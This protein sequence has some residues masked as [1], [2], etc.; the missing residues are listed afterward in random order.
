MNDGALRSIA[1]FIALTLTACSS[2]T[3]GSDFKTPLPPPS[4]G[5]AGAHHLYV[6]A[7]A[8]QSDA[9]VSV[10]DEMATGQAQPVRSFT[11]V[12]PID[13]MIPALG[14]AFDS[15]GNVWMKSPTAMLEFASNAS[16]SVLPIG[17][18]GGPA[19]PIQNVGTAAFDAQGN[20]YVPDYQAPGPVNPALS[21]VDVFGPG[22]SGNTPPVRSIAG[23]ATQLDFPQAVAFDSKGN[24]YVA[25]AG[26]NTGGVSVTVYAPGAS[27]NVA[28]IHRIAG[29]N[30]QFG[31]EQIIDV[32]VDGS[33]TLYVASGG[34]EM[35]QYGSNGNVAPSSS[36]PRG[37]PSTIT[38]QIAVAV[39]SDGTIYVGNVNGQ[40][41]AFAP[42]AGSAP[43]RSFTAA[44]SNG[45]ILGLRIGP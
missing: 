30:T 14:A 26:P 36:I 29:P 33:D 7:Q 22:A 44:P 31:A 12:V 2:G 18:I 25:N 11:S 16:G 13:S 5:S 43:V 28:P 35:F 39:G 15:S 23:S 8:G 41:L 27:G 40:V 3:T 17:A 21:S 38:I 42:K 37:A 4:L 34:I 19:V 20:L 10:F 24:L 32:A 9:S 6:T 45:T 1:L